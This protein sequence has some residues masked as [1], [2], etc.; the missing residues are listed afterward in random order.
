MLQGVI[1]DKKGNAE[2]ERAA[3]RVKDTNIHTEQA[4][5]EHGVLDVY[6]ETGGLNITL[7]DDILV[8]GMCM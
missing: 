2:I 5:Y 4:V 3:D 1:L 7:P 8:Q 6:G